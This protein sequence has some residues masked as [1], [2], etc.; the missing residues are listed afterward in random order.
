MIRGVLAVLSLALLAALAPPL[1]AQT[2]PTRPI[3]LVISFPAGGGIDALARQLAQKL[4]EGLG[5]AVVVDNRPGGNT[6]ISAE[7]VA[8]S[9]PDG[10]TL[11]M[12]LDFTMTMNPVL[13]DKLPYNPVRDFAPISHVAT[14]NMA[15]VVHPKLPAKNLGE[16]IAYAKANPGKLNYGASA[17]LTR[18]M[19]EQIK[20]SAGIDMVYVPFKGTAPMIQSLLAG[21]IDLVVD[22]VGIY[23]PHI[24]SGKLR[25][26][27]TSGPR[28]DTLMPDTPTLRE[29]GYPELETR[30]WFALYAPA[31]TSQTII[32]RLNAE[33][34]RA[35][36]D[37]AVRER[38]AV[39]DF[40]LAASTPEQLAASLRADSAKW[41][42]IIRAIGIKVE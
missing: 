12:P 40:E 34:A 9:A 11:F 14:A 32:A 5:Q 18:L 10:Y 2:Y 37:P 26:L 29:E 1:S 20:A 8:R 15:I 24:K 41:A 13:Y 4:S 42:P 21:D 7:Q 22:G 33:V 30:S 3:R 27:A 38:L 23:V 36:A 19:G 31:S 39:F 6:I 35:V 28:R 25:V 17:V 16:L